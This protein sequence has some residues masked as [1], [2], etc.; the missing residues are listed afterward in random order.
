[1]DEKKSEVNQAVLTASSSHSTDNLEPVP[2]TSA[3][4]RVE[5][6][7][8]HRRS[9]LRSSFDSL[10]GRRESAA[11][12]VRD[13]Y[14]DMADED[15]A[16]ARATT[17]NTILSELIERNQRLNDHEREEMECAIDEDEAELEKIPTGPVHET[18]IAIKGQGDEFREMDPELI[19]WD[20]PEDPYNPANWSTMK[21]WTMIGFVSAYALVAPMSSSMLSPAMSDIAAD[22]HISNTVVKSM[23]VSIQILAWAVGPLIIAPLSEHDLIGRKIV[24]DVSVWMS[25]FFNLG[26][27]FSQTT[28][29]MMVCRFVG[30]IFGCVP[31]NVCA[32]VIADMCMKSESNKVKPLNVNVALAGYSLAPLLG[33]V[34]APVVSGFIVNAGLSWRWTFYVLSIFNGVV[35][36]LATLFFRETYAPTLLKRKAQRLRKSTQ[37]PNLHTIYELTDGESFWGKIWMTMTKPVMLLFTHPMIVSLGSLM[38]FTY[39][40]MYLMITAFPAIF[41]EVYGYN[42][43]I[44]G[45]MYIPM[46]VGF[47]LGVIIW[48]AAIGRTYN[49][50]VAKNNG[51]AKPEFR[52]PMLIVSSFFIPV[53]LIWFGW[54]A[55]KR[56]HW[57]MPGIGSGLFAFGLVCL[58]Q[59]S[60]SYFIDMSIHRTRND[61]GTEII[62]NF[63]ASTVAAAAMF[64]SLFGFTFPLF[65]PKMYASMGYGWSNT[66]CGLI[67]LLLIGYPIMC[68]KYGERIRLAAMAKIERKQLERDRKNLLRLKRELV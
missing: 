48:T 57:I 13:I 58:F 68:Y 60:Q 26:C 18:T 33:P 1:M 16:I 43:A 28:A 11:L 32:G 65:A 37:N 10:R 54:S 55:E 42:S 15:I 4:Y 40:F 66:M 30:G 17:K 21:K 8:P 22:F 12:S 6:W 27:A 23:V 29:Q 61:E 41:K 50:L 52:L 2:L 19:T 59:S 9:S 20:G 24:L 51:V 25:L 56:L 64:R 5:E 47:G 3:N 63:S 53:G 38:A 49:Y 36:I 45:L 39:G 67:A 7:A 34:I 35:A 44:T 31:M 62:I 14:G 46:G